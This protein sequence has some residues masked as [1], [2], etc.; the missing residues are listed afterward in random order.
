MKVYL[1]LFYRNELAV[2]TNKFMKA[3][4]VW[5]SYDE[6][7]IYSLVKMDITPGHN[8]DKII[9]TIADGILEIGHE[10]LF[11]G[12]NNIIPDGKIVGNNIVIPLNP[13][14]ATTIFKEGV[15][16]LHTIQNNKLGFTMFHK[17]LE[18]LGYKVETDERMRVTEVK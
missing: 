17:A 11:I 7:A 2:H 18:R 8:L 10:Y 15:S 5:Q 4:D 12:I 14:K 13:I 3:V 1:D 16:V 9:N 6:F